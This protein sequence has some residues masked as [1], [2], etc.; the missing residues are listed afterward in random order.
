M[1]LDFMQL[2]MQASQHPV[3]LSLAARTLWA[4]T[5]L[6]ENSHLHGALY[7]HLFDCMLIM[8]RLWDY[9]LAESVREGL[10]RNSELNYDEMRAVAQF[11][12]GVHDIGK[13]TPGFECKQYELAAQVAKTG[14]A[15]P[16]RIITDSRPH[17]LMG[18]VILANWL[19]QQRSW[20]KDAINGM[21]FIVGSHHGMTPTND[22]INNVERDQHK[23]PAEWLGDERWSAVQYE[24][25]DWIFQHSGLAACEE[26]VREH[27][28]PVGEQVMLN[29]LVIMADWISSN[30]DLFPLDSQT[31]SMEELAQRAQ[32]AWENLDVPERWVPLSLTELPD[33]DALF[34][35]RFP[36]LPKGARMRQSQR[37]M[38]Q[39]ARAMKEPGILIFEADTGSGKT[40]AAEMAAE[41]MAS[42]YH[43]GGVSFM[44]PTMATSDAMWSRV[45]SW[46]RMV[47]DARGSRPRS[48]ELLHSKAELNDEFTGMKRW[49][50]ST[51][52][53]D[54]KSNE[55]SLIAH[56]WFGGRKRGLLASFTVGTVDQGLM[57]ALRQPHVQLRHLGLAGKVVIVDEVHAY[58]AYMSVYLDRLLSYLGMYRV[59][60]I[61][62][63]ATL[64]SSKRRELIAAYQAGKRSL[65]RAVAS[66][67]DAPR[68]EDGAP[69]YPLVT[70]AYAPGPFRKDNPRK[71]D[72]H[73]GDPRKNN[74]H[75][76][77]FQGPWYTTVASDEGRNRHV[78][79]KALADDDDALVACLQDA[80]AQGGCA[81]VIRDTVSRAQDTYDLLKERLGIPV[82]LTH[83]RFM[84]LDRKR[85]D[86]R[87][88]RLLGKDASE[89]P[90]ALVV[91]GTQVLEQS[92]DIDFDIMVSDIAPIDLLLQRMGRLHRHQ[93]G[94][95]EQ[96]RPEGLRQ[97]RF[98]VTGVQEWGEL[99]PQIAR[100]IESVY[101][102]SLLLRTLAALALA[103]GP[104]GPGGRE[105]RLPDDISYLVDLVYDRAKDEVYVPDAWSDTLQE[106]DDTLDKY[107]QRQKRDAKNWLIGALQGLSTLEGW[108]DASFNFNLTQAQAA[109]RDTQ[110]S[111]EVVLVCQE[112]GTLKLL[113]WAQEP[114]ASELG[115]GEEPPD[116]TTTKVASRCTVRLPVELSTEGMVAAL[117]STHPVPGWRESRWLRGQ[118]PLALDC[119]GDAVIKC[120]EKVHHIH[121]DSERGLVV[122]YGT[123]ADKEEGVH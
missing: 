5:G 91:V 113:P 42:A 99:T 69:A 51:M 108:L 66:M 17:A 96:D 90:E 102:R 70:R 55:Q 116:D 18:Q 111:L 75:E 25:L 79:V 28:L 62:L 103:R 6:G 74:P 32:D 16:E 117:E 49:G 88:L 118:L 30:V 123:S 14:L 36:N 105:V 109:V 27:P 13:A 35:S 10:T 46:L 7:V 101:Q 44:L 50:K 8:G 12:A 106:A 98:L 119:E 121:Y 31:D 97:P 89:R 1:S 114:G 64:P 92:L 72:S 15:M 24:L 4:K 76:D 33:D 45:V 71:N 107:I 52:G 65:K 112:E 73:K 80:L 94:A 84:A 54:V 83:S 104:D 59:P 29:A 120:G 85:N 21:V 34:S 60:V 9:W 22:E 61:L 37:L 58:D 86:D 95:D 110:D 56:D 2:T 81:C 40:E 23:A 47:P 43:E 38:V 68:R 39:A 41:I 78:Q 26:R 3:G 77:E 11:L 19:E 67:P 122:S 48:M 93:R 82:I 100:G 57:A 63:S 20:S 87:L 115:S 53:D